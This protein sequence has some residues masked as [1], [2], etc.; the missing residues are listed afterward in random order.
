M[1]S[2]E[3]QRRMSLDDARQ[4]AMD[5]G[6]QFNVAVTL[7]P[8]EELPE[9]LT[10]APAFI[11][12]NV[13]MQIIVL[14]QIG[15]IEQSADALGRKATAVLNF[16]RQEL[17]KLQK[18]TEGLMENAPQGQRLSAFAAAVTFTADM[19][20]RLYKELITKAPVKLAEVFAECRTEIREAFQEFN[21]SLD[22]IQDE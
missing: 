13:Q 7:P 9:T 5:D 20:G 15:T 11:R 6:T 18:K 14:E 16:C 12:R 19:E 8:I 2:A 21:E 17:S 3:N 1:T 22:A 10:D 4:S